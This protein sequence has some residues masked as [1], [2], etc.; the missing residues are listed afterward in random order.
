MSTSTSASTP[1]IDKQS[2]G[3]L[4]DGRP[5]D[6]YT[7]AN[8]NGM[9]VRVMNYGCIITECHVPDKNGQT[10]NVVLGFD[11]L[12]QYLAPHPRF[13]SLIGR[14]ANR[15]ANAQF[16]ID[17]VT[18]KL[19]PTKGTTSTH[20]G[21]IGFDKKLWSAEANTERGAASLTLR[22]RSVDMEEGFPGN[23]DVVVTYTLDSS[24]TLTLRYQAATDKST[25]I[26]LTNHSYFNLAG[27]GN[28]D[29]LDH[30]AR[31]RVDSFTPVDPVDSIPTGE[32]R[33]VSGTPFDFR[34]ETAIGDR[35]EETGGGYDHNLVIAAGDA[36]D[37]DPAGTVRDPKSRRKLTFYTDQPAFQFFTA[38]GLNGA[39]AGLGGSYRKHAGF[40][41][42]TQHFPD[43]VHHA[44]FPTVILRPGDTF[45]STT[46]YQF[47]AD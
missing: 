4:P 27:A 10:A 14:F 3:Q 16:E 1:S 17:G 7:L 43:S 15:I 44:N 28:G 24:N 38:N 31:F 42:E 12:Q 32:I 35:I 26:N 40:C 25:P 13:G 47:S 46:R 22:Y 19:T 20:G 41:I 21:V 9:K 33:S 2:F 23:L 29:I 30:L 39:I 36:A 34:T 8:S 5:V 11:N 18:Y 45:R 37:L 6:I